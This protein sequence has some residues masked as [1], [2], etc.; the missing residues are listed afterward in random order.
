[1]GLR[2]AYSAFYD[3]EKSCHLFFKIPNFQTCLLR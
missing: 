1:M 3:F 2:R